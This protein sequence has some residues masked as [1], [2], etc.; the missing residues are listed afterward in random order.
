MTEGVRTTPQPPWYYGYQNKLKPQDSN[1][2]MSA[3][4]YGFRGAKDIAQ[5]MTDRKAPSEATATEH[6]PKFLNTNTIDNE[7]VPPIQNKPH[8]NG[9]ALTMPGMWPENAQYPTGTLPNNEVPTSP[10]YKRETTV[11]NF[12]IRP[13]TSPDVMVR[14]L[15]R[16]TDVNTKTLRKS[17]HLESR[18][19]LE[20][21]QR[22]EQTDFRRTW[23]KQLDKTAN[24]TLRA[25]MKH[26]TPPYMAHT[27]SDPSDRLRYSDSTAIITNS[28]SAEELIFKQYMEKCKEVKPYDTKWSTV[29]ANFRI[30]KS[31]LLRDQTTK[32]G[33]EII[34]K[35]LK[36]EANIHGQKD[37][38]TRKHFITA[39]L[40][41]SYFEHLAMKQISLL[42]SM[43]DPKKKS[44]ICYADL[45]CALFIFDSPRRYTDSIM[46]LITELWGIY[47][48]YG[49]ND[50]P[51]ETAEKVLT[52]CCG[53]GEEEKVIQKLLKEKFRPALYR[54][55]VRCQEDKAAQ[56]ST[57]RHAL[58]TTSA[59]STCSDQDTTPPFSSRSNEKGN[60]EVPIAK[61]EFKGRTVKA[62]FN[63]YDRFFDRNML[64]DV[65]KLCPAILENF[66]AQY[67]ARLVQC[68]GS[69]TE[70]EEVNR[71]PQVEEKDFS[72][73]LKKK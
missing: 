49:N 58:N 8:T 1:P 6:T 71:L 52:T 54:L 55:S 50:P 43:F 39:M 11:G 44:V 35:K 23:A 47:L 37:A 16:S 66:S 25:S 59:A 4:R 67:E 15:G 65:L 5:Y 2:V 64:V 29:I 13:Y 72:W 20:S 18:N 17:A 28:T 57:T 22:A 32:V 45:I 68:Y 12:N 14:T 27:L 42:F 60:E 31:R 48:Q 41:I 53:S 61:K 26:E 21:L 24:A 33:I 36:A 69:I 63:I 51:M 9:F 7:W 62:A 73:I 19:Q 70:T 56:L 40:K 30:I 38:L 3:S 46:E 34:A 10:V